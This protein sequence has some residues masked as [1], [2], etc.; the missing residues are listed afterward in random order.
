MKIFTDFFFNILL[1]F[2][3][4]GEAVLTSTANLCFGSKIRKIGISLQTVLLCISGVWGGGC[5]L[6]GYVF[7][8]SNPALPAL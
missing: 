7:L 1:T 3:Q 5:S 2:A 6:H 4:H 8:M